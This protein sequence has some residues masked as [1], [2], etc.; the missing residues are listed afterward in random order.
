MRLARLAA[1]LALVVAVACS[2]PAPTPAPSASV[3]ASAAPSA[4]ASARRVRF[5]PPRDVD[6]N[7][8]PKIEGLPDAVACT[9]DADCEV[10]LPPDASG[11]CTLSSSTPMAKTYRA[12]VTTWAKAHCS[13]FECPAMSF[14]GARPGPCFFVP[15]CLAKRCSNACFADGGGQLRG[16]HGMSDTT[17]P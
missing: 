12:A 16:A 11:C 2:K 10:S 4:S 13:E 6:A 9:V 17:A 8:F 3:A 15:R 7:G 5:P 14:P 1:P